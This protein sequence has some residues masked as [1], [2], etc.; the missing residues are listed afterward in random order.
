MI[1]TAFETGVISIDGAR[2][3]DRGGYHVGDM[4]EVHSNVNSQLVLW[5]KKFDELR[6]NLLD[7]DVPTIVA[8][9][10]VT[11]DKSFRLFVV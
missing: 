11:K 10:R 2:S 8:R 6:S 3:N 5:E 9:A 1:A 7:H 4:G